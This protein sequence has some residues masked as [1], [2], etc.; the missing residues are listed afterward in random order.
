MNDKATSPRR[1][2]GIW[3]TTSVNLALA[4]WWTYYAGIALISATG[5]RIGHVLPPEFRPRLWAAVFVLLTAAILAT[6]SVKVW[7]RGIRWLPA[8]LLALGVIVF[9][10]TL[11]RGIE[12]LQ[13]SHHNGKNWDWDNAWL[14]RQSLVFAAAGL[15]WVA[16]N[17]WYYYKSTTWLNSVR[18][19]T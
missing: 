7:S 3:A 4:L 10:D 14:L 13:F 18:S 15:C 8:M 6:A 12:F 11:V 16:L 2:I 19:T 17:I 9:C 5:Y 1:P